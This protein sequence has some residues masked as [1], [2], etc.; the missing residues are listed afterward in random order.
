M[1]EVAD[2]DE[3]PE[4]TVADPEFW[5]A[6]AEALSEALVE[7]ADGELEPASKPSPFSMI[8]RHTAGPLFKAAIA[9]GAILLGS[10]AL[11]KPHERRLTLTVEEA[12]QRLGISRAFAYEAVNRGDIPHIKIGRRI[13]VPI[14][15]LDRLLESA[16]SGG[17]DEEAVD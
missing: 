7:A 13:L 12:A 5:R 9:A 3:I 6:H 11:P 14:A 10:Q 2:H 8:F 1:P 17:G 4:I 16:S 15:A